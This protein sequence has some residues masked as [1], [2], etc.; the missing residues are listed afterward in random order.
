MYCWL[1]LQI[2]LCCLWL[3]L[4]SRDT[5]MF[6]WKCKNA[7]MFSVRGRYSVLVSI[8]VNGKSPQLTETRVSQ[9]WVVLRCGWWWCVW[10]WCWGLSW[11]FWP[12]VITCVSGEED[13]WATG[14]AE[15]CSPNTDPELHNKPAEALSVCFWCVLSIRGCWSSWPCVSM[16]ILSIL[17]STW[18][19][20]KCVPKHKQYAKSP[21]MAYYF[22]GGSVHTLMAK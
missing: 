1:L 22:R 8:E 11:L 17:N 19:Y 18:D 5:L 12:S 10:Q 9:V 3:L 13:A 15:I 16:F 2:Y 21:R 20:N 4:C 7:N 6:I 14:P